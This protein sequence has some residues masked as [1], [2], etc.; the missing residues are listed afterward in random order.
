MMFGRQ[1]KLALH[2][3]IV[4]MGDYFGVPL[5]RWYNCRIKGTTGRNGRFSVGWA[6]DLV[7][8]YAALVGMPARNDRIALMRYE[9]LVLTAEVETVETTRAQEK[10]PVELHY[11]VIRKLVA[12][13]IGKAA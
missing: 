5:E 6:S 3:A 10:L 8:E 12:V 7:R 9:P 1:G 13:E 4:D 11:S 2:F